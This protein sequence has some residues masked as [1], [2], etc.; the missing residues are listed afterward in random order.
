VDLGKFTAFNVI[1]RTQPSYKKTV[2]VLI[3]TII[4]MVIRLLLTTFFIHTL[5]NTCKQLC[6]RHLVT[7]EGKM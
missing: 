7:F 3:T 4:T 1:T 6:S 5:H 2:R